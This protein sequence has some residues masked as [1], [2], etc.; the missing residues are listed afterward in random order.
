MRAL[1]F[2]VA[3]IFLV[4]GLLFAGT[5]GKVTGSVVDSRTGEPLPSVNV[6][7]VGTTLGASTNVEGYFTILNVPPGKY[8]VQATLVG[9]K[10]SSA[11]D[12]RVDIDQTTTQ[13]FRMTEEAIA[14]E[15]VIVI[16]ARPVVQR[17]VSASRANIEI[18]DVDKLPVTSVVGAVGLQAGVQ[19][20]VI[21]GG[22][23][24]QTAFMVDGLVLRDERT[25]N[26]YTGIS[27]STVQDIQVQTGGFNAEY[28]NIRSGMVNVVTR[29]G[30]RSS[31]SF[32]MTGRYSPA[33]PK[34]FG[35]SI[36]D[37][38]GYWIRPY[39]D[40][41]V[42]WT[43]TG[44]NYEP[45][46]WDKWTR[47][48]YPYFEGWNSVAQK[49]LQDPDPTKHLTPNA[50]QQ[51]FLWEYRKKAEIKDPDWDV[52]AGFGGPVPFAEDLGNLRFFAGYRQSR[53][54]Y[55]IPLSRSSFDEQNAQ[56]KLTTDLSGGMKLQLSGLWGRQEGTNDNN[57]GNPGIFTS[58]ASIASVLNRISYIDGRIFGEA[59]WAPSQVLLNLIGAKF[60]HNV[61]PNVFYEVTLQ[62]YQQKTETNPGRLRDTSPIM[63]FGNGYTVD[64][65]PFGWQP[66]PSTG[67]T[68]LRMGVGMSNSRDTSSVTTYT[69]RFDMTAQLDRYNQVKSGVEVNYTDNWV[70]S[71][72]V[73]VFL[74]SGRF[75]T[76]WHNY[77]IRGAVYLQDK[78]EF[79]GM[80]AN[81]GVRVDYLNPNGDWFV[82]YNPYDPAFTGALSPGI[83]TLLA[84]EKVKPLLNVSPR[85]G[86]SFPI[87]ENSKLYFNYGHFRQIPDPR[88]LFLLRRYLDNNQVT[89]VA[90]PTAPLPKTVAYEL[91]YE[92]SLFDEYLIRVAGY[93][94]DIVNETQQVEYVNS[95]GTIDY[96]VYTENRYRDIRGFE[97]TMSKNRGNWFQGF[98]NYTYDVRTTGYF[99]RP[100]YYQSAQDQARD[101][102]ANIYQEKPIPQP[103][104][105]VN[106]DFFTPREFGPDVGGIYLLGDWRVN[107]IGSWSSGF[108]FTWTGGANIPG[109]QN[110]VQ[111]RD[112]Y[113]VDMRISKNF[114]IGK[115]GFQLFA[116]V[117]NLLNT[118]YL[119]TYG[120]F[121]GADY[122]SYMSSLHLPAD[123]S[124]AIGTLYIPGD[125]RPGDSRAEG[126]A[127][128]PIVPVARYSD[129]SI[130][131]NQQARP[132]Y[133]VK[134]TGK[135]Y[136]LSGATWSEVD[137]GSL[138]KVMDDKAYI[139][140]PNQET[141]SFL[142][143]RRIF[144][145][146]RLTYDL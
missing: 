13:N 81:I 102:R 51:V 115:M 107:F 92:H 72:S 11:I 141:F 38:N 25:N 49:S 123:I 36:Y 103:Y 87:S 138:Q 10:L 114:Q 134:E 95:S 32:N 80:V 66:A 120:F 46:V 9:Y 122:N 97:I 79:E 113:N 24:D 35:P 17:D 84:K 109:I 70:R 88:N 42:A 135:Y 136:Q 143:P 71:A 3:A 43:G 131:I 124:S 76:F 104:A 137:S 99:G 44:K 89:N 132:F 20:L 118:K 14:G 23:I 4:T 126:V 40:D 18:K 85:L 59:Y 74:P 30:G 73:D 78:L 53:S 90:D 60:T 52:D 68:G 116:D 128:Q 82:N 108:Y 142:N 144:F 61:N 145:G 1:S 55:L 146:L 19:G 28:G 26:P 29:E 101:E 58:P 75:R 110:N 106:L 67:I 39:V 57:A 111:W 31:Y 65:A 16:A 50:A 93:Y 62:R 37:K 41:A 8:R 48:Q 130:P 27:L 6:T 2:F 125:D 77:P 105:R 119:T 69:G 63:T 7:I 100:I 98:A 94:K 15:E 140:M 56:I 91:G 139:D 21:R 83:D 45:G 5:T 121:D 86:I 112:S 54:Y 12:V 22:T 96:L 33:R 133:Y 34:H 117:S 129:L 127:Y 47:D 64:E